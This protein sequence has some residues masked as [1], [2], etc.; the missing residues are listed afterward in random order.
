MIRS[1][2]S[3]ALAA[4][5]VLSGVPWVKNASA[6]QDVPASFRTQQIASAAATDDDSSRNS[7]FADMGGHW[8]NKA[9]ERLNGFGIV[10]GDPGGAYRPNA[11][12]SRAEFAAMVNRVF[13]FVHEGTN[14]FADVTASDWYEKD[15]L[16]AREAGII[17]GY[18]DGT[19]KPLGQLSRQDA[20]LMLAKS[21]RLESKRG[22]QAEIG[23]S[24]ANEIAAYARDAIAAAAEQGYLKGDGRGMLHPLSP[25]T[26]AEAAVM[27][28]RMIGWMAVQ[29][30][31]YKEA[32]IQGNAFVNLP[33]IELDGANIEGNLYVT[34]GV[35]EGNASFEEIKVKGLTV[36][37]GGGENS[38]HFR[39]SQLGKVSAAKKG[40]PVRILL[41]QGTSAEVLV[42]DRPATIDISED[43]KVEELRIETAAAGTKIANKGKLGRL[44]SEAENAS[45]NGQAI[46]KGANFQP[47]ETKDA[48]SGTVGTGGSGGNNGG[49]PATSGDWKLVWNDEFDGDAIDTSKWN[50]VDTGTV[51]NNELEY[52]RPGN[53]SLA[54]DGTKGVLRLTAKREDYGGRKYTSAKLTSRMKGDWTY[55][56]FVV[57]AKLPI[58]QGMWPAIWMMPTD[59]MEQYGPWPG[60]GEMDI[61]ELT[62]PKAS[63][64]AKADDYPRTVHGSLH[65]DFPRSS[66]TKTYMLPEG[67]TFADDYHDFAMEWLPGLIRYYVDDHLYFESRDWGTKRDGQAEY[68]TYPA[69]FDRPFYM[70]LNL[71]VGGDWPG[72]PKPDFQTDRMDIDY[73][74]VYQYERLSEWPDV[75]GQR[76]DPS[77][78]VEP[79]RNPL[80]DGN[81]IYNG[82]FAGGTGA[83]GAPADWDFLLN[84]GGA[85]SV[86]VVSDAGKDK[87]AKVT[88]T[89]AGVQKYS[90]QLTQR[91]LYMQK[92]KTYK[93]TFEAKADEPRS[94][95]SKVTEFGGGWTA[96]SGERSFSLTGDWQQYEYTFNMNS[97]SDNNARFEFNLGQGTAAAYFANVRVTETTPIVEPRKALPDGNLIFNGGFDQGAA[98]MGYWRFLS[99]DAAGASA[100]VSNELVFPYMQ[101][102]FT[103]N[104]PK[105][106]GQPEDVQLTQDELPLAE[107]ETY[108]L[109]FD[110]KAD[111]ARTIRLALSAGTPG[112]VRIAG[113]DS[114]G[115]G[116]AM[117]SYTKDITIQSG[118]KASASA[119]SFQLGGTAGTVVIDN[120]RLVRRAAPPSLDGYLHWAANSYWSAEGMTEK[121]AA[122]GGRLLTGFDAGGFAEYKFRATGGGVY[123]PTLRLEDAAL[124]A[125]V[126]VALLDSDLQEIKTVET[127]TLAGSGGQVVSLPALEIP[128]GTC[129]L[130]VSG[131]G[132]SL[133]WLELS[134]ELAVNGDFSEGMTGWT[135]FKKDWEPSD[136]VKDTVA[137][138]VY[139]TLR[140]KLG[141]PGTEAWNVQVKQEG[142]PLKQGAVYR[143]RFEAA[144][145]IP[146]DITALLQHDG[147]GDGNWTTY[148]ERKTTLGADMQAF[149]YVFV[150]SSD[151]P[152]AL[153]QFSMGKIG[154]VSGAHEISLRNISLHRVDP[155]LAGI[156]AGVNLVPN[157]DFTA[158]ITGWSSYSVDAGELAVRQGDKG[159]L[160]I[161]VSSPGKN[162]YDRQVY[163]EG[164]PYTNGHRYKLTFKAKATVP[165]SMNVSVG[166]LDAANNYAW[167]GY[168]SEIFELGT[169]D[170]T[171]E[172]TFDVGPD[173]TAI[174]R[175]SFELGLVAAGDGAAAVDIDDIVLI[176]EGEAS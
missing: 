164:L 39:Q 167:H 45:L 172:F 101:R 41:E 43:S 153:L 161:D 25:I 107:G 115:L 50:L 108:T 170:Q 1:I 94:L 155:S 69:P 59:E 19:F 92:G 91:P 2:V 128:A 73:V 88:V 166:W 42:V 53:A 5:L 148:L 146:R 67:Q 76:P 47:S 71:A 129:F 66:Q 34:D 136:P 7:P 46:P 144:S 151:E 110:A 176:D 18:P 121:T 99:S 31:N 61:M 127:G 60:S 163:Y 48:G 100:S 122:S 173:S 44:V 174:G 117:R 22:D 171:Y 87:A 116:T 112:G 16:K 113:G 23:F 49:G 72:D 133:A 40:S 55:G 63:D 6:A 150:A 58:Q 106:G 62:G 158:G 84:E 32:S 83:G 156:A 104:S 80:P 68:Y 154:D 114:V 103:A 14:G 152:S 149:D 175:L 81:Q 93:V 21:L 118:E 15:V 98:R 169:G 54:K 90:I 143:L 26:R 78:G 105:D 33:G 142:K 132:F 102:Q 9:A 57:R 20:A 36:V 51:Y 85:G 138:A 130:R 123:V 95:M 17:T 27:L 29:P 159:T 65:Y 120:V 134:A 137:E 79:Q 12:V 124:D 160:H 140:V 30:G 125:K 119:L 74:R 4:S 37:E 162:S 11:P 141:G 147:S 157:G 168:G 139:G 126:R 89:S 52:Y 64:P 70:I 38:V 35:G 131:T 28:D 3:T 109:T 97:A 145:S 96:Y 86:S 56:K 165:R 24:D 135:L 8:A 77:A 82:D 13:K 111:R 10:K 75:T